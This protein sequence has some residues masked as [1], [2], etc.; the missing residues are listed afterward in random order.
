MLLGAVYGPVCAVLW[1]GA[2]RVAPYPDYILQY[3][4]LFFTYGNYLL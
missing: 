4:Y 1:E 2:T 3:P